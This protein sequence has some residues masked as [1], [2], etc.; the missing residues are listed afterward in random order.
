MKIQKIYIA[1]KV[2]G[3]PI[4]EV[5]MKFGAAQKMLEAKG[6][7]AINPLQVVNDWQMPWKQAMKLCIKAL[8]ECDT[9]VLLEDYKES[10]GALIEKQIAEAFNME[11]YLLNTKN[12]KHL[13][14]DIGI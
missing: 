6:H 3:L 8:M 13:H 10:K 7:T 4:A 9:I 1:G 12:L 11:I 14:Y 2:T 5:T